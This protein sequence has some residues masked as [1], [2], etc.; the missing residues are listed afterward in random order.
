MGKELSKEVGV[1]VVEL[2][3]EVT[4]QMGPDL[5]ANEI[6]LMAQMAKNADPLIQQ[7]DVKILSEIGKVIGPQP[8]PE[9]VIMSLQVQ[10]KKKKNIHK[11]LKSGQKFILC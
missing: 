3:A 7:K 5:T 9:L 2:V 8:A 11:K 4:A 6:H 1:E 10:K